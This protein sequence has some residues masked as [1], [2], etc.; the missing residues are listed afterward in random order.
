M[1]AFLTIVW[2]SG[3]LFGSTQDEAFFVKIDDENNPPEVRDAGMLVIDIAVAP[4]KPAEF[5]IIRITQR[6]PANKK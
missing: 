1:T 4:V 2:R 6:T 3:A 5:V